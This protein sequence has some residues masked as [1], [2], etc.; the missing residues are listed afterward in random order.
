M[1]L[2]EVTLRGKRLVFWAGR[3]VEGDGEGETK[4]EFG[5]KFVAKRAMFRCESVCELR[6]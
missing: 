4:V 5:L 2:S 1:S 6:L 3:G